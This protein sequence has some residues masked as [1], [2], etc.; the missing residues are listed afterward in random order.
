MRPGLGPQY[1]RNVRVIDDAIQC[2]TSA[3]SPSDFLAPLRRPKRDRVGADMES[4]NQED[5]L[6]A[7]KF[8]S[9]G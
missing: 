6:W 9:L 7:L 8:V 1:E 3:R 4:E 5:G 2:L